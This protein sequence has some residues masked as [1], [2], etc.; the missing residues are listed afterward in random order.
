MSAVTSLAHNINKGNFSTPS[1]AIM[2]IGFALLSTVCTMYVTCVSENIK[3][4][5]GKRLADQT[6]KQLTKKVSLN[7]LKRSVMRFTI[8]AGK[9]YYEFRID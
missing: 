7:R 4:I 6:I 1:K 9:F 2:S 8:R 5:T 3:R